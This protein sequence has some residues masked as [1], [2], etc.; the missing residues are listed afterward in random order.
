M[1]SPS[2]SQFF[3]LYILS[4]ILI[5]QMHFRKCHQTGGVI[6][7]VQGCEQVRKLMGKDQDGSAQ[8]GYGFHKSHMFTVL[9]GHKADGL[10]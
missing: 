1:L 4:K 7:Q 6:L 10:V 2:S 5:S 9:G 3:S 8:W